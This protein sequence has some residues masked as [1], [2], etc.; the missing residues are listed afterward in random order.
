M[1]KNRIAC[2]SG[3]LALYPHMPYD[4]QTG[5]IVSDRL[6]WLLEDHDRQTLRRMINTMVNG[7]KPN[8]RAAHN[9]D[10]SQVQLECPYCTLSPLELEVVENNETVCPTAV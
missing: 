5:R 4:R 7:I 1:E 8:S 2:E 10:E 9:I 3:D 6:R